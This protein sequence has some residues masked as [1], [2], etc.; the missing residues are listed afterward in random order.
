[1]HQI[2]RGG[3]IYIWEHFLAQLSAWIKGHYLLV[4]SIKTRMH[5]NASLFRINIKYGYAN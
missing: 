3:C 1:M 5:Q 4:S 2:W